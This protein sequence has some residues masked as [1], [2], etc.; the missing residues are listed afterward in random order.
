MMAALCTR[1][2]RSAACSGRSSAWEPSW[3]QAAVYASQLESSATE[4]MMTPYA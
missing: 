4:L 3:E 1:R 2:K